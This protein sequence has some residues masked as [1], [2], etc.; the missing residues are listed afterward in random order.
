MLFIWI[1]ILFS[2]FHVFFKSGSSS[3]RM[4]TMLQYFFLPNQWTAS[5]KTLN[6]NVWRKKDSRENHVHSE[7][8]F[9]IDGGN[10]SKSTKW[11]PWGRYTK[12]KKKTTIQ[13]KREKEDKDMATPSTK[14][15]KNCHYYHL[16]NPSLKLV[17]VIALEDGW[18]EDCILSFSR[19]WFQI[20]YMF[21]LTWGN[22]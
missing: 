11:T 18:L 4:V 5:T 6:Y 10:S 22:D 20:F 8:L 21:T 7:I 14:Q 1:L 13:M 2:G 15:T 17:N 3:L 19:W 16:D 12:M 9:K